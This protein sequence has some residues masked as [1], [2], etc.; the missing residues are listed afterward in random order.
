LNTIRKSY[1]FTF[2][3]PHS[4]NFSWTFFFREL[5]FLD[6][7]KTFTQMR[8]DSLSISC[9]RQDFKQ[10]IITQEVESWEGSTLSF[11]IILQSFCYLI[12]FGIIFLKLFK[13]SSLVVVI[14]DSGLFLNF[15]HVIFPELINQ[16]ELLGFIF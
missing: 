14:H 11:K 2:R 15:K 10:F 9:L 7:I 1:V 13:K 16:L 4:Q 8:L 6:A 5:N 12:K 3:R